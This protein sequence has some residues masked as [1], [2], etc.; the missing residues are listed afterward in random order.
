MPFDFLLV[1][2][3]ES[4]VMRFF[5][6]G[7]SKLMACLVAKKAE[8]MKRMRFQYWIMKS[9]CFWVMQNP[10]Y[11]TFSFIFVLFL[12]HQ[13]DYWYDFTTTIEVTH[14]TGYM[15][16]YLKLQRP[17]SNYTD[18]CNGLCSCGIMTSRSIR[19]WKCSLLSY[20]DIKI[21]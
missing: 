2:G 5:F 3:Y 14:G 15:F 13:M 6:L 10:R 8:K 1:V 21:K 20:L 16:S 17:W 12:R 7:S 11:R 18:V 4:H 19:A 9:L